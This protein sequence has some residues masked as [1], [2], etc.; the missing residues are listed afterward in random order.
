MHIHQ[1]DFISQFK[2][3]IKTYL[4]LLLLLFSLHIFIYMYYFISYF[5]QSQNVILYFNFVFCFFAL[6]W[7]QASIKIQKIKQ[8]QAKVDAFIL[9]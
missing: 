2:T 7:K 1:L 9:N 3:Q 5:K 8:K 4:L 6:K